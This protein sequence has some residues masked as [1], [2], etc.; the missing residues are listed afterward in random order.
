MLLRFGGIF[1]VIMLALWLYCLL[2]AISTDQAEVR[3][4]P[5][6]A[7]VFIVLLTFEVGAVL[8]LLFGRPRRGT[9]RPP[10]GRSRPT[11]R[12]D[13]WS[14]WTRPTTGTGRSG[15]PAPDDDPEF[16]AGLGR[17]ANDEHKELLDQWEADLRRREEE[18]RRKDTGED[19]SGPP[20]EAGR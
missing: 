17:R 2:D 6:V 20:D 1:F 14:S 19:S 3:S 10:A 13:S 5:K 16:L 8:W 4:L 12:Y 9:Q 7:W 18:L 11:G 15:K